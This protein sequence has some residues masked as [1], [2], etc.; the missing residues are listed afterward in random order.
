MNRQ[1]LGIMIPRAICIKKQTGSF[2]GEQHTVLPLLTVR[3]CEC[4]KKSVVQKN[5]SYHHKLRK[6]DVTL[7]VSKDT[8]NLGRRE[9]GGGKCA[10]R[11]A[12]H[13]RNIIKLRGSFTN[14][15][16]DAHW[17]NKAS[18]KCIVESDHLY[19]GKPFSLIQQ[20]KL[21]NSISGMRADSGAQ[22]HQHYH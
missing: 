13:G 10:T 8:P 2:L 22:S 18:K 12:R 5:L 3:A 6:R 9:K 7:V 15:T 17:N 21:D 4:S 16:I 11:T 1:R 20:K 19:G 14:N